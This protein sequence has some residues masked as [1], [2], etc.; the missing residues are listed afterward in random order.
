MVFQKTQG[1]IGDPYIPKI[2]LGG[3]RND[4]GSFRNNLGGKNLGRGA[5][6]LDVRQDDLTL[7]KLT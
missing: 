6:C 1:Q 3:F 7:Q 4:L 2:D 5:Q